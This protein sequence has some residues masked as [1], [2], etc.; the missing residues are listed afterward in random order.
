MKYYYV[1]AIDGPKSYLMAGPYTTHDEA[2]AD[3]DLVQMFCE[4][5]DDRSIWMAW[6]TCC[7]TTEK[8]PPLDRVNRL[9]PYW[10]ETRYNDR[11]TCYRHKVSQIV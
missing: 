4:S 5:V 3:V 11:L 1:S 10:R 7:V 2:L 9:A 6:G 8:S